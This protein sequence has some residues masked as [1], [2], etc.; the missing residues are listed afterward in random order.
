M[1]STEKVPML[2]TEKCHAAGMIATSMAT[3]GKHQMKQMK[4]KSLC[5]SMSVIFAP[6]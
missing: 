1:L 3:K 5:V 6:S 4:L 2:S